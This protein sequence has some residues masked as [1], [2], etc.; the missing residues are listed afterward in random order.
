MPSVFRSAFR[1][2]LF[3]KRGKIR[4]GCYFFADA[5]ASATPGTTIEFRNGIIARSFGP[6]CSIELDCSA[7]RRVRKFGQPL[8]FSSIQTFAKLLLRMDLRKI[9][10]GHF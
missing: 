4:D 8:L 2:L 7:L 9:A 1:L 3:R 6:S 5:A 10:G